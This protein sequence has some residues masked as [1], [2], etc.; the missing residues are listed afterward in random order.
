MITALITMAAITYL[1]LILMLGIQI[2]VNRKDRK[3]HQSIV[4]DLHLQLH[5][6]TTGEYAEAAKILKSEP[7]EPTTSK[8]RQLSLTDYIEQESDTFRVGT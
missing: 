8:E 3:H 1:I 6:R 2:N 4:A 7:D 5:S